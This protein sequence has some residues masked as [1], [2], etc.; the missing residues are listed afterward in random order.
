M[1]CSKYVCRPTLDPCLVSNYCL[2]CS[3]SHGWEQHLSFR[4]LYTFSERSVQNYVKIIICLL[5]KLYHCSKHRWC[6][7]VPVYYAFNKYTAVWSIGRFR[8]IE[9]CRESFEANRHTHISFIHKLSNGIQHFIKNMHK[10]CVSCAYLIAD[11]TEETY[12][13]M[14]IWS[15]TYNRRYLMA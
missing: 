1:L 15:G 11:T 9:M 12:E 8:K 5:K 6:G 13:N 10:T 3:N 2:R 7:T 14:C 4:I